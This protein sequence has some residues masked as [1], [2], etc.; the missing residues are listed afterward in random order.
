M[1]LSTENKNLLILFVLTL[2]AYH[3]NYGLFKI[4]PGNID[5]LFKGRADWASHYLGWAFY[6]D[7]PWHFPLGDMDGYNYPLGANLGITDSIPLLAILLK[8]ISFLLPQTFQYL[9]FWLL[10]C[11]FMNGYYA[12]KILKLYKV[13][14]ILTWLFIVFV[15]VNP[16]IIYRQ[17]HVALCSHWVFIGALYLYL[18]PTTVLNVNR[19]LRHH[20]ILLAISCFL[21]PYLTAMVFGF[22]VIFL[23]RIAAIDK[24]MSVLKT[25]VYFVISV[26]MMPLLWVIIGTLGTS[27]KVDYA[28]HDFFGICKMNLNALYNPINNANLLPEQPLLTGFQE[29]A[30]MYLGAGMMILVVVALVSLVRL[31]TRNRKVVFQLQWIPLLLLAI[32]FT[33]FA[34]THEVS[35]NDKNVMTIPLLDK[36]SALGD[37][38]RGNGRFF[39]P[40]Y[41]MLLL[42]SFI[43]VSKLCLKENIKIG[44]VAVALLAQ[45]YDLSP[46]FNKTPFESR[47]YH[48]AVN[49]SNWNKMYASF[50]NII[51][52]MPF[53]TTL[54]NSFDYQELSYFAY[55]NGNNITCEM[56]ARRDG[57][58]IKEFTNNLIKD[59]TEGRF[60]QEN[61]YITS[62]ENL[63]YFAPAFQKGLIAVENL[64]GYYFIYNKTKNLHS[65]LNR[66][67][68]EQAEMADAKNTSLKPM[69]LT[70]TTA[71]LPPASGKIKHFIENQLIEGNIFQVSGWAFV[72]NSP[73][74]AGDSVFVFVKGNNKVFFTKCVMKERKDISIVFKNNNLDNSGFDCFAFTPNLPKGKYE[75]TLAIKDHNKQWFYNEPV[76]VNIGFKS[77]I[78]PQ[79]IA[80]RPALSSDLR[81]GVDQIDFKDNKLVVRGWCG[82]TDA[83]SRDAEIA[84]LLIQGDKS[85]AAEVMSEPRPDVTQA[86]VS[87]F[88][89]DNSG[90][91]GTV[92]VTS[93][94]A[95]TFQVG[96]RVLNK[97]QSKEA[98]VLTGK[99]FKKF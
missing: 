6:R 76:A 25:L 21:T 86:K 51:T 34:L 87:S 74:N 43:L 47:A 38:F 89:M 80:Q 26:V 7:S 33:L 83:D 73:N 84:L 27:K 99:V 90:F 42:F 69:Q 31:G 77:E 81:F 46:S 11:L 13:N 82:F 10:V 56:A 12:L 98:Y 49:E 17:V 71:A 62:R 97:K 2:L 35:L 8:P 9:G 55:M 53:E 40:V 28:S 37:I 64:D 32:G 95:G 52:V 70:E 66:S 94:P 4:D 48:P 39:W 88:N 59:I 45:L 18:S 63:K 23:V 24:A 30:I 75:M 54:V 79:Q 36:I 14:T 68:K 50:K 20:L 3:V 22:F 92:N 78:I 44:L 5:W 61:L 41:Y 67:A 85:Y 19:K 15:L 60:P 65:T 29:D 1:K 91:N 96:I 57:N 93:L 72:E 58:A 16:V